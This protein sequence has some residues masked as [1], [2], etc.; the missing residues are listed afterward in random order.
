[1]S[2]IGKVVEFE[3]HTHP[4]Q[5]DPQVECLFRASWQKAD[6]I[7]L[8][9]ESANTMAHPWHHIEADKGVTRLSSKLLLKLVVEIYRVVGRNE[10]VNRTVHH[11]ELTTPCVE[12]IKTKV[13]HI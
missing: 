4:Y 3:A 8:Q 7:P 9:R 10:F 1:M 12:L 11:D 13:V 6:W 2:H 5:S